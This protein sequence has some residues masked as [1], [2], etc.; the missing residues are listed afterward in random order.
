MILNVKKK[1]WKE[2]GEGRGTNPVEKLGFGVRNERAIEGLGVKDERGE[3][4][5][6]EG[7]KG[8]KGNA[9]VCIRYRNCIV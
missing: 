7:E 1:I 2:V 6:C 9:Y 4:C 5:E 3:I 8:E